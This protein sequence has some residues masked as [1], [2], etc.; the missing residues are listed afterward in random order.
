MN[1]A[2]TQTD[3]DSSTAV[4]RFMRRQWMEWVLV[5]L[6]VVTVA[7]INLPREYAQHL[8]VRTEYLIIPLVATLGIALLLYLKF[9]VFL[10]MILLAVGANLPAQLAN[11]L[12]ISRVPFIV[13]MV[14][15]VII[16][17]VNA[18]WKKL[19]TGLEQKPKKKSPEAAHVL[20]YA[21]SKGNLVYAQRI[22]N[23]EYDPNVP[24]ADGTTPLMAAAEAGLAGMVY[25]LLRNGADASMLNAK[26]ETA[27]E[28]AL[29]L[30]HA[31]VV[32]VLRKAR[33]Q[34]QQTAAA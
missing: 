32:D 22:L 8:P 10:M 30:G 12:N 18:F 31:A 11:Q 9:A 24:R 13:A 19:P 33:Q 29:R 15:M 23:E 34:E 16:S 20:F 17:L 27:L 6:V 4:A 14:V 7:L 25:L 2:T 28:I 26:G 5:A 1:Q 3:H 21:I